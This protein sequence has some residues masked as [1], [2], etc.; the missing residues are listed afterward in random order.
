[1][2]PLLLLLPDA[3]L[4]QPYRPEPEQAP[5]SVRCPQPLPAARLVDG[6]LPP[7]LSLA[8]RGSLSGIPQVPGTYRFTLEYSDGCSRQLRDR[9]L[10][11]VPAAVLVVESEQLSFETVEGAP[12]FTV[13]PV[14]VSGSLPGI[15]YRAEILDAPWL[16]AAPRSGSIPPEGVGLEADIIR[17]QVTPKGLPPG[18]F[19]GRLRV[20]AWGAANAPELNFIL[21]VRAYRDLI[22]EIMPG[23]LS[24]PR[25]E[26]I[27]VPPPSSIVPPAIPH[28]IAPLFPKAG[29]HRTPSRAPSAPTR[30]R[31]LPYPKV[32]LR[33]PVSVPKQ[34]KAASPEPPPERTK[35]SAMP[36]AGTQSKHAAEKPSPAHH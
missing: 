14:R 15:P 5:I 25:S 17:L 3:I 10:R 33:P 7:G 26:S 24:A 9:T 8:A 36:P 19:Q 12:P 34:Q 4:H 20:S 22:P 21:T 27:V 32:Q 31:V 28:T 6:S 30:S 35:P 29:H 13:L 11:V 23:S 16:G 18:R 2:L 1:M